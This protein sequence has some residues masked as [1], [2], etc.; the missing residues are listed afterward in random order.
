MELHNIPVGG[1]DRGVG[2]DMVGIRTDIQTHHSGQDGEV[3]ENMDSWLEG[4]LNG[5][6][7]HH[8]GSLD[9]T[10]TQNQFLDHKLVSL[11]KESCENPESKED[12]D[13]NA[14]ATLS[15]TVLMGR[16]IT[17]TRLPAQVHNVFHLAL[18]L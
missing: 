4:I 3:F 5:N 6:G 18:L 11:V 14:K 17:F 7:R 1:E 16:I 15:F 8:H 10:T 12:E 13:R 2:L 9:D